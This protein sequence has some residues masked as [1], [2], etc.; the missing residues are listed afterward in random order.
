MSG[1]RRGGKV[2]R[3]IELRRRRRTAIAILGAADL[4]IRAVDAPG[5]SLR[6]RI[7]ASRTRIG[8]GSLQDVTAGRLMRM[9]AEHG[10]RHGGR[11]DRLIAVTTTG[12]DPGA[13]RPLL[14][15]L[16][17][18]PSLLGP[19]PPAVQE[20]PIDGSPVDYA[21]V[22]AAVARGLDE[23]LDSSD[24]HT[25]FHGGGT[26]QLGL[27]TLLLA[28]I[29]V[30]ST[31][32]PLEV[33][34]ATEDPGGGTVV[35]SAARLQRAAARWA[36]GDVELDALRD[37]LRR[38]DTQ[39]A[40]TLARRLPSL[41][42]A[43]VGAIDLAARLQGHLWHPDDDK[44]GTPLREQ[45]GQ[46]VADLRAEP[47]SALAEELDGLLSAAPLSGAAMARLAGAETATA[48][49]A[50]DWARAAFHGWVLLKSLD[51][52]AGGS[53]RQSAVDSLTPLRAA[54]NDLMHGGQIEVPLAERFA[55]MEAALAP[56][57]A[58]EHRPVRGGEQLWRSAVQFAR[59]ARPE[60]RDVVGELCRKALRA[61]P[62]SPDPPTGACGPTADR[63]LIAFPVADDDAELIVAATGDSY[64]IDDWS[65]TEI[66]LVGTDQP[67]ATTAAKQRARDTAELTRRCATGLAA[68]LPRARVA[69]EIV[70]IDLGDAAALAARCEEIVARHRPAP[71]GSTV[72]A[73][74]R[75]PKALRIP[76]VLAAATAAAG[77]GTA[78]ALVTNFAQADPAVRDLTTLLEAL[79]RVAGIRALL[80]ELREHGRTEAELAALR[81]IAGPRPD[82]EAGWL[83]ELADAARRGASVSIPAAVAAAPELGEVADLVRRLNAL[84]TGERVAAASAATVDRLAR[85]GG[86]DATLLFVAALTSLGDAL[87]QELPSEVA[88]ARN[89]IAHMTILKRDIDEREHRWDP[90]L[91]LSLVA[92]LCRW[93]GDEA[94]RAPG[95]AWL[96]S[97]GATPLSDPVTAALDALADR[98]LPTLAECAAASLHPDP[99]KGLDP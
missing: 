93:L 32:R 74:A 56:L 77:E 15:L 44:R 96:R 59:G 83:I 16:L 45:V 86:V 53:P 9:L 57:V 98:L 80:R 14:E 26:P 43:A 35:A 63:V 99:G 28:S 2:A 73:D 89:A 1:A 67:A 50:R 31:M 42:A 68:M 60:E 94:A 95:S 7:A 61:V 48:A 23:Q 82:P 69:V 10:R 27:A 58:M 18:H 72:V 65:E 97:T 70:A 5:V 64:D 8:A 39:L 19:N 54:R 49:G 25:L 12:D 66:V 52:A 91:R 34:G 92:A 36:T 29:A 41:P 3:V 4:A 87:D 24:D 62:A 46:V 76:T 79:A 22:M 75:G 20:L 51:R 55:G 33:I 40:S 11:P 13:T 38:R 47:D 84:S 85:A 30:G 21:N 88:N 71:G 78:L 81:R 6:D 17:E 90:A 37:A